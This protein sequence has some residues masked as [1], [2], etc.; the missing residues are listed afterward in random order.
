MSVHL[1]HAELYCRRPHMSELELHNNQNVHLHSEYTKQ[2]VMNSVIPWPR[3]RRDPGK[4]PLSLHA[5]GRVLS[6]S[7]AAT[8]V[9]STVASFMVVSAP[10][11]LQPHRGFAN[12]AWTTGRT[13]LVHMDSSKARPL[14][15]LC[16]VILFMQSRRAADCLTGLSTRVT[17]SFHSKGPSR[18]VFFDCHASTN[19]LCYCFAVC[20]VHAQIL[21]LLYRLLSNTL[22]R[23]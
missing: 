11:H 17:L 12:C 8:V 3:G 21:L 15:T 23:C 16:L 10:V 5:L 18:T 19:R 14:L 9:R 6:C 22:L 2:N 1:V 13:W 20:I 4:V 7:K